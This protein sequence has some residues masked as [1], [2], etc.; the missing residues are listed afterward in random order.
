MSVAE[1]AAFTQERDITVVGNETLPESAAV[2]KEDVENQP[3]TNEDSEHP[4]YDSLKAVGYLLF[5]VKPL[6]GLLISFLN[7]FMVSGEHHSILRAWP[8]LISFRSSRL[9]QYGSHSSSQRSLRPRCY[10]S[11]F[12][13]FCCSNTGR[14]LLT[15]FCEHFELEMCTYIVFTNHNL[16]LQG[17]LTDRWGPRPL[18]MTCCIGFIPFLCLLMI[19]KLPLPAFIVLLCFVGVCSGLINAVSLYSLYTVNLPS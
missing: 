15:A 13:L 18:S 8:D 6:T 10:G 3:Q 5:N 17:Y 7:G 2:K 12:S 14:M 1:Q 4:Q 19:D 9:L 16:Y 11:W